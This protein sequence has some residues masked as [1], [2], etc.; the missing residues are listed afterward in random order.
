MLETKIK[1]IFFTVVFVLFGVVLFRSVMD[2]ASSQNG[3][4]LGQTEQSNNTNNNV[5]NVNSQTNNTKSD[6][7]DSDDDGLLDSEEIKIYHTDQLNADTDGDGFKDG[8]EIKNGYSPLDG[9]NIKLNQ[10]DTDKDGLND[11]LEL[12][13]KSDLK[14]PDTD[15]DGHQD[16]EEVFSGWSPTEAGDI[17]LKDKKIEVDL[18][19]QK[20]FYYA[21]GVKLGEVAVSSGVRAMPTPTGQ[22]QIL[23]KVPIVNYRGLNYSYPN[24]KWNLRFKSGLYIH[25]AYWHNNF[26]KKAMSHGCVNVGY[27]DMEK[28]YNFMDAGAEVIIYGQTPSGWLKK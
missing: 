15:G 7:L 18:S 5:S 9:N 17:R 27:A 1:I 16:G 20:L 10:T 6:T 24:T 13:L 8:E 25:G 28:L 22:F 12:K 3:L 2:T 21:S 23:Q 14:N 26:G 4:V 19:Q 11:D